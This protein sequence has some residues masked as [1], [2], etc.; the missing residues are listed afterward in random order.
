MR[1]KIVRCA[2]Y[3]DRDVADFIAASHRIDAA[4]A[5]QKDVVSSG[6]CVL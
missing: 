4:L 3:L 1:D 5:R 6:S 2:G